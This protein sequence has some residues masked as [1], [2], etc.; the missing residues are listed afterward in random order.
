MHR[1]I[2]ADDGATMT[3]Y[4][5]LVACIAVIVLGA[6]RLLGTN[7]SGAMTSASTTMSSGHVPGGGNGGSNGSGSGGNP[8]G[9]GC[10]NQCPP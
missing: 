6:V 8:G 2:R 10:G 3:E 1:A 5:L 7:T 9:G 4:A